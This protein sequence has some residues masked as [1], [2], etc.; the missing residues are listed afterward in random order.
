[1]LAYSDKRFIYNHFRS[2]MR[3]QRTLFRNVIYCVLWIEEHWLYVSKSL[4]L[5][6]WKRT[7][8]CNCQWLNKR[9]HRRRS[10]PAALY[11]KW[12]PTTAARC[13]HRSESRYLFTASS[14]LINLYFHF[15][16]YGL[17]TCWMGLTL[18]LLD[19]NKMWKF[20]NTLS[21]CYSSWRQLTIS[22]VDRHFAFAPEVFIYS[23]KFK[24]K[25]DTTEIFQQ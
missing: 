8:Q 10:W 23:N 4:L 13:R 3:L 19:R 6:I 11:S 24:A 9:Y 17:S 7:S 1:M 5:F 14:V 22:C 12:A 25:S 15:R 21:T 2:S 20:E 18:G 16:M